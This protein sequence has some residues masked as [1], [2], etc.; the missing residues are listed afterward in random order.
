MLPLDGI[1]VLDFTQVAGG[2]YGAQMLGDFGADVI[3]I[4]PVT[5]ESFRGM[6][7]GTWVFALNRNKRGLAL[8]LKSEEGR[9]IVT[10]LIKNSDIFFEAFVPGTMERLGFG[11]DA[12]KKINP[13]I[14]YCSFSGYGQK[15]PFRDRAGYDVCAQAESGLMAATGEEGRPYVRVG[16]SAIDYG[17]GLN[18]CVGILLALRVREKTGEGQHVDVS[19][20]DTAVSWM[21]YRISYYSLTGQN[22]KRRGSAA[23]FACP[24]QV[25]ETAD[26]P[27]FIGLSTD[28]FWNLLCQKLN[29]TAL[30]DDPRFETNE[31]RLENRDILIPLFQNELKKHTS[32]ELIVDLEALGIPYAQVLKV[33]EMMELPH[34]KETG[35]IIPVDFPGHG[36]IATA[37][38]P[39]RLSSSTSEMRRR[40]PLI[41]EHT[42]EILKEIGYDDK[43]I[44]R[45]VQKNVICVHT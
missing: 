4:E 10:K 11:Y 26:K 27:L 32:A 17:T 23:T 33:G 3:K 29:L 38:V 45:L 5:G 13:R 9:E 34:V 8:S 37:G 35:M 44:D 19:L 20:L 1:K 36:E 42:S 40:A 41:G 6:M 21:N 25:F 22:T 30:H 14:I 43:E 15:G 7:Q 24:Y 16:T 28:K 12:V 31:S 39:I 18:A 2:P